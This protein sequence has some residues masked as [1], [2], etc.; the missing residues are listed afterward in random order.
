MLNTTP[1]AHRIA[2]YLDSQL[3][4]DVDRKEVV[5]YALDVYLSSL[6]EIVLVVIVS[7]LLGVAKPTLIALA[8]AAFIRYFS[9]GAHCTSSGRCVVTG[10][11]FMTAF[12][13]LSVQLADFFAMTAAKTLRTGCIILSLS[14]L[15]G[16]FIWAPA[17]SPG[18][19]ITTK[20]E[21]LYLKRA[22]I[23]SAALVCTYFIW[24]LYRPYP[25]SPSLIAAFIGLAWQT[26]SLS[27]GGEKAI[28]AFDQF[29][30]LLKI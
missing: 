8:V 3:Q 25:P 17:D 15:V 22:S 19:P 2:D 7:G 14:I 28:S 16:I 18:K 13:L 27:P 20:R 1:Y 26:V 5:V 30:E 21:R 12:G 23:I 6:L 29:L 9:G 24:L 10:I 11:L 4:L